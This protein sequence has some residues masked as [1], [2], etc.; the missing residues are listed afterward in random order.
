MSLNFKRE[1]VIT[2]FWNSTS[3]Y[4]RYSRKMFWSGSEI[5]RAVEWIFY[6]F[7][8]SRFYFL[9][10]LCECVCLCVSMTSVNRH[11]YHSTYMVVGGQLC[12]VS[13]VLASICGCWGSNL[14]PGLH[15]WAA[16]T[17]THSSISLSPSCL[18]VTEII[19]LK[20]STGLHRVSLTL[21]I[22]S[23]SSWPTSIHSCGFCS[24]L[25]SVAPLSL[26]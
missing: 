26:N 4:S 11:M 22:W 13:F 16:S 24:V 9:V 17:L 6:T 2:D 23:I 15:R 14:G 12:E 20:P 18:E 19:A 8:F 5:H 21:F 1:G 7:L 3:R 25:P 10:L